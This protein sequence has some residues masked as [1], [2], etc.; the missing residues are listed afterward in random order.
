MHLRP[1]PDLIR[2]RRERDVSEMRWRTV[3][4]LFLAA[5]E[6]PAGEREAYLRSA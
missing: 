1:H 3:Q 4:K 6:L 2:R 5:R